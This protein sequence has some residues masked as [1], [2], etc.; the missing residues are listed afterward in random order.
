MILS[1]QMG[2]EKGRF[3][4]MRIKVGALND[5]AKRKKVYLLTL[6]AL[7]LCAVVLALPSKPLREVANPPAPPGLIAAHQPTPMHPFSLVEVGGTTVRSA[8]L[9]GH[10]IVMRFWAT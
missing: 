7:L 4:W 6:L 1:E 9:R 10:V 8:D 5:Q 3:T 2:Q